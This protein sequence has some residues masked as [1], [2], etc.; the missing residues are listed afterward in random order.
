MDDFSVE[1][2]KSFHRV[3]MSNLDH[4]DAGTPVTPGEYCTHACHTVG[5]KG[6][7]VN[8][9]ECRIGDRMCRL[10]EETKEALVYSMHQ[11]IYLEA[12]IHSR[13]ILGSIS[14]YSPIW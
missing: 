8:Y 11:G 2:I 13:A 3:L 7:Q 5:L 4:A 10:V 14:K 9:T 6:R 12:L 1:R